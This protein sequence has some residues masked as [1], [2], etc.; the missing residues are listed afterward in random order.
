[1][2]QEIS[3]AK[4]SCHPVAPC[5]LPN[6]PTSLPSGRMPRSFGSQYDS[7]TA[8]TTGSAG[9]DTCREPPTQIP[10]RSWCCCRKNGPGSMA[11]GGWCFEEG[12]VPATGTRFRAPVV[13]PRAV[14]ASYDGETMVAWVPR[15]AA[16]PRRPTEGRGRQSALCVS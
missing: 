7:E 5:P 9:S 10:Y 13:F 6:L 15:I 2:P 14:Y 4:I 16:T 3:L 8:P 11:L 12:E 1:L